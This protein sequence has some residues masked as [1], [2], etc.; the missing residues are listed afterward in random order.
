MKRLL[1]LIFTVSL[2]AT[3]TVAQSTPPTAETVLKEATQLAA[4]QNKKVFIIFHASWCGWCHRMDGIMNNAACKKLFDDNFVVRH[5][6]VMESDKFKQ[7]EN[8]GGKAMMD[9]YH[10]D[11]KGIPFWL[12]FDAKGKLVADCMARPEGVDFDQP[13]ENSGCPATREEVAHF[14]KVL[15]QTTSLNEQQLAVIEK[16]FIKK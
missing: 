3:G 10:G 13:G 11:G 5:L 15:K 4:K 2:F 7:N 16:N 8:P 14:V 1:L 9:K 12:I 6:T